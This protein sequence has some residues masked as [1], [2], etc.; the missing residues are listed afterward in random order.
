LSD[1]LSTVI[2]STSPKIEVTAKSDSVY[3]E[4][5][6]EHRKLEGHVEE[7]ASGDTISA[8]FNIQKVQDDVLK[9]Y[10]VTNFQPRVS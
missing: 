1:I 6:L 8:S 7:M 3:S 10:S 9:F 5:V 2:F 4:V